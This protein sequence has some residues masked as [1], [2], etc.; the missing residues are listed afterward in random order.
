MATEMVP[1]QLGGINPG[2]TLSA[3]EILILTDSSDLIHFPLIDGNITETSR[4]ICISVVKCC[5]WFVDE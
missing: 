3:Y 5:K 1:F 2:L 4:N